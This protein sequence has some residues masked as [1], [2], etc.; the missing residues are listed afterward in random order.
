[1]IS[2]L[3]LMCALICSISFV[4]CDTEALTINK[5]FSG[6]TIRLEIPAT[7]EPGAVAIIEKDIE[8]KLRQ[9][10]ED[11][12][13]SEDRLRQVVVKTVVARIIDPNEDFSFDQLED[14]VLKFYS[15]ELGELTIANKA[16]P[17]GREST[18]EIA[19]AELKE[20]LLSDLFDAVLSGTSTQA[21][22]EGVIAEID[23]T[24]EITAGL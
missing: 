2:R 6:A 21:I 22:G 12:D 15:E 9:S 11:F 5:D 17:T 18:F 7:S 13:I 14:I 1:M 10:L 4:A 16:K 3:T 23:V 8:T 24:Y 19:D 20:F